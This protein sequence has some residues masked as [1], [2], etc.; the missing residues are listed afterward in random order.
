MQVPEEFSCFCSFKVE[1]GKT[2]DVKIPKDV[3]L[4]ITNVAPTK[5]E[6]LLES[7]RTTLLLKVNE[8]PETAIMSVLH[9][10]S[11]SSLLNLQFTDGDHLK[12]RVS[13]VGSSLDVCGYL[14]NGYKLDININ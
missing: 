5:T 2:T 8:N 13:G 10:K 3:I 4:I 7:G 12:F 9:G 1:N 6:C 14:C 11:E